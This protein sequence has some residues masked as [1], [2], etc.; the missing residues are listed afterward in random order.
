M[1]VRIGVCAKILPAI[2]LIIL[3]APLSAA[4][5][6]SLT[7]ERFPAA[8]GKRLVIDASDVDVLIR[9][10][11]VADIEVT[12]DLSISGVGAAKAEQWIDTHTPSFTDSTNELLI[13]VQPGATVGLLSIGRLT[14][15]ARLGILVPTCV[16]PDI[17]TTDGR[18]EVRGDF[19]LAHPLRMRTSAGDIEATG[20][21]RSLEI[22]TST[23]ATKLVLMRAAERVF[24]RTGSG[25]ITL[26]GGAREVVVDTAS[27]DISLEN[28]SGS[29]RVETSAGKV[30]LAWD[31]LEATHEVTVRSSSGKVHLRI[32][33][34]IQPRGT[35]ATTTGTIESDLPGTFSSHGYSYELTGEGPVLD[36][37]T[38]STAITVVSATPWDD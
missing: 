3:A 1:T 18:I 11:D 7:T 32:P 35:L 20:A 10:A 24:A 6:R 19:P 13:A 21:A 23:G 16:V 12:T 22:R 31:R 30:S 36:V 9:S 17:T 14:S 15:R 5:R 34:G 29:A 33:G 26:A 4:E 37:E 25:S 28:L 27:G 8:E 38:A 2:W